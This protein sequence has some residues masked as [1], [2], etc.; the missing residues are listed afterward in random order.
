MAIRVNWLAEFW[1]EV[2][3]SWAT[4]TALDTRERR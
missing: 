2:I 4:F 1:F 3:L